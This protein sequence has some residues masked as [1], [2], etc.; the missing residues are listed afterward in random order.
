MSLILGL[1]AGIILVLYSFY[2]IRIIKG[3]PESFE[4]E[5]LHA[6]ADWMIQ[7]GTS[8]RG[9]LWMML[10]LAFIME[11]LYF[12]LVFLVVKNFFLLIFTGSLIF[13]EATHLLTL[14]FSM[15][16][17]FRGNIKLKQ[18]FNWPLERTSAL[19]FFTHSLLILVSIILY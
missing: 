5:L 18:L 2:F 4:I 10:L 9:Q 12:L 3:N 17:F 7:K 15:L 1:F 13:L 19:L 11:L 8:S 16:R 6:L 14:A